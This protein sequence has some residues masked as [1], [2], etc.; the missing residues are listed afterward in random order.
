LQTDERG[1]RGADDFIKGLPLGDGQ[2]AKQWYSVGAGRVGGG[3]KL[4]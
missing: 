1:G 2:H 4:A 3:A